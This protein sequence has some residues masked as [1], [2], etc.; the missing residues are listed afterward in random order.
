MITVIVV[1]VLLQVDPLGSAE[2]GQAAATSLRDANVSMA[3]LTNLQCCPS[4]LGL[5][6]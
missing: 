3:E 6:V 1:A 5:G 4:E 2:G